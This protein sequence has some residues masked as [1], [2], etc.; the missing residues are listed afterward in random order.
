MGSSINWHQRPLLRQNAA[1]ANGYYHFFRTSKIFQNKSLHFDMYP[2][3][4]IFT[5]RI[6]KMRN[7][8]EQKMINIT[9]I[10]FIIL[11]ESSFQRISYK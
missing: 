4:K 2:T 3:I 10:L 6:I 8:S 7:V 9:I 5:F 1:N 11:L